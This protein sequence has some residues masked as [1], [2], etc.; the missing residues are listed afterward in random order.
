MVTGAQSNLS[1]A[2]GYTGGTIGIGTGSTSETGNSGGGT[3]SGGITGTRIATGSSSG[4]GGTTGTG[5]G[6]SVG[7]GASGGATLREEPVLSVAD[8]SIASLQQSPTSLTK[9]LHH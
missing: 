6:T 7:T 2:A 1:A 4:S 9:P 3:S 5:S 8:H